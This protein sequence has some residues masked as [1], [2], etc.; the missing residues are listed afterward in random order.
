MT[1]WLIDKNWAYFSVRKTGVTEGKWNRTMNLIRIDIS[2]SDLTENDLILE[3][4]YTILFA[5]DS[6]CP[7]VATP[8]KIIDGRNWSS[9]EKLI[10]VVI[11]T[12]VL[13]SHRTLPTY[14]RRNRIVAYVVGK[15]LG[16]EFSF[17]ACHGAPS[18]AQKHPFFHWRIIIIIIIINNNKKENVPRDT[19]PFVMRF[20]FLCK[21]ALAISQFGSRSSTVLVA[22]IDHSR[23]HLVDIIFTS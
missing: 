23:P 16:F 13:N 21:K 18:V 2:H 17:H 3:S 22:I 1:I 19:H 10:P 9:E 11:D 6:I 8:G 7:P 4:S 5:R 20:Y 15:R 14:A 12:L